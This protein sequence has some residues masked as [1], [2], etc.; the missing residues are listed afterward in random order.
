MSTKSATGPAMRSDGHTRE[1]KLLDGSTVPELSSEVA[2][3]VHTKCPQKWLAV[4]ME[5]GGIWV[6]SPDEWRAAGAN[7]M[8]LLKQLAAKKR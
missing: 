4:D 8:A 3:S 1:R 7:E 2:V 6:R 5:T